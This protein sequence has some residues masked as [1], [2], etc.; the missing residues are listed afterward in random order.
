M[1]FSTE[2]QHQKRVFLE[3]NGHF[4]ENWNPTFFSEKDLDKI[5]KASGKSYLYFK[6]KFIYQF[7]DD[8]NKIYKKISINKVINDIKK[9]L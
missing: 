9:E 6:N 7:Q 8:I 5:M 4:Y 2:N 3:K 1:S